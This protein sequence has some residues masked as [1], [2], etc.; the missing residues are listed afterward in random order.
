MKIAMVDPAAYTLPYDVSLCEALAEAGH[1]VTLYT[2]RFAHGPMPPARGFRMVE[3]FYKRRV[4]GVP[5]RL[6][7]ALQHAPDL[8]RLR[9]RLLRDRPD[10]VHV[11]W[12][13]VNRVDLPFWRRLPLPVVFTAHNSQ[14]RD[15]ALSCEEL[16]GFNAVVV[17]SETGAAALRERCG[18][19]RVWQVA[20][21]AFDSFRDLAPPTTVP[22]KLQAGAPV[23]ALTGLLRQYKGAHLLIEAWPAVRAAIPDAQLVIAGRPMGA[24]L[25]DVEPEGVQIVR[26]FLDDDE[27]AWLLNRAN[28]VCLPYVA[29]DLSAVL[30]TAIALGRPLLLSDV[31]GF[32][33][34]VGQGAELFE[35]G[36]TAALS[37]ALIR[38]LRDPERLAE[39]AEQARVAGHERYSWAAIGQSYSAYY[40]EIVGS[41][42]VAGE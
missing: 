5:R 11:Q 26:R 23:V 4:P 40:G 28:L 29:I 41:P 35:A 7:R 16:R 39:L 18:L 1:E 33:E 34:F 42:H 19:P 36:N 21:G 14:E 38:L 27:Y 12:S 37:E 3:W 17:H 6:T 32:G 22:V 13:V 10:V 8:V 25:P 30:F 2:T 20:M 15:E 9:R 24:E 31:G